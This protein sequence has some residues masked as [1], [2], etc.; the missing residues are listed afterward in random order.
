MADSLTIIDENKVLD[1]VLLAGKV[2]LESGAET[3]RVEDTMGRIAASFGLDDTYAFVTSTAIMF[4][5][6]DRTNTR[7]VRVRERTT[8]LEK[9]A[10]ANNVSRKISQN[11]ITLDEAK[12]ELI[13]L[14]QASLQFSF[15]VKFLSA[16][17]ASGFFLFMFGGVAHDFI[18]AVMA[19]AGAFLTFDLV[20]RYIQIKFFSEFISSMVVIA[21][22]ASFTKLG[23]TVNQDIITIAGVMP[24]VPGI[25]ITNAIRDLMAGELLAGMSRGVEAALTAF[26]IG[27]GVAVVLIIF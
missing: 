3:Y 13:H 8:D 22:A 21:V 16:A 24:L 15:I 6:N 11:K 12:T 10:I 4:S 20:Q 19:G 17:I 18:Y 27:A 9:T 1:V 25:L 26:A 14:E 2:L 5:L 23:M 7:L